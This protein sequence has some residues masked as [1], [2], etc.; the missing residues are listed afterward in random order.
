MEVERCP[1][2]PIK[3]SGTVSWMGSVPLSTS[4]SIEIINAPCYSKVKMPT[5]ELYNGTIDPEEHLGVYKA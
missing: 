5:V 2:T 4:F 1:E 3:A